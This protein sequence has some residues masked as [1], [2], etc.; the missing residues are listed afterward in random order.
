MKH[1]IRLLYIA[2][3]ALYTPLLTLLRPTG[4]RTESIVASITCALVIFVV[5]PVTMAK[6][7]SGY[8]LVFDG[9]GLV[10]AYLFQVWGG[11]FEREL[12]GDK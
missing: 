7:G 10:M 4:R 5:Q 6:L 9:V 1:I 8:S 12:E 3:R 2:A 11:E